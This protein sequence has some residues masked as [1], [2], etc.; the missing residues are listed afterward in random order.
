MNI[1]GIETSCDE[2]AAAIVKNG[3]QIL[4]N[5][6]V[7]QI[8]IHATYG[9]VVPEIAARS[10]IEAI[11]PVINQALAEANLTWPQIDAIA[12]THT[13][14]LLGSLLI[15]TLTARTLSILH[16]K[17]LYPTHH[18]KSHIYAN[19]LSPVDGQGGKDGSDEETFSG[20]RISPVEMTTVAEFV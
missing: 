18:L 3:T 17:P 7:S 9:G 5:I 13:P 20:H 11:T 8:N 1:L 10:H 6:V 19:W 12:V 14:G 4:S 15:G 2:T 16:K